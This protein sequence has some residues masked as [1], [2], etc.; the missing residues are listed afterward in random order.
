MD[1]YQ[2]KEVT[3]VRDATATDNGYDASKGK[4][5]V[6]RGADGSEKTVLASEITH[7]AAKA[8]PSKASQP[9]P[10][11]K[12]SQPMPPP[13]ASQP[14]PPAQIKD[15]P[16]MLGD[17]EVSIS[18]TAGQGDV[19]FDLTLG[20]QVVVRMGDGTEKVVL[21]KDLKVST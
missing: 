1:M 3:V 11:P 19:G 14:M 15:Q 5:V 16:A 6:L 12:A 13:S 10:P 8:S 4:Q 9:M 2:G 20:P 17:A 21:T 7:T 18:R